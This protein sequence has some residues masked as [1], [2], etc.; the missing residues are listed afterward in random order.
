[1]KH[2]LF[3]LLILLAACKKSDT[4]TQ[5]AKVCGTVTNKDSFAQLDGSV[6]YLIYWTGGAALVVNQTTFGT[7][8][9]GNTICVDQSGKVVP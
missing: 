6:R 3:A 4:P 5:P 7:Y 1:M 9:N 2:T 8:A